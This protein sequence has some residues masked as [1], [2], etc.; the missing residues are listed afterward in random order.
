MQSQLDPDKMRLDD[1][2][3]M[4]GDIYGMK[5]RR[6]IDDSVLWAHVIE[7]IGE[8]AEDLR[9]G[10]LKKRKNHKGEW[11]G[12]EVNVPD[13]FAWL[14]AFV[15]RQGWQ[16]MLARI[17]GNVNKIQSFEA[18][19]FHLIEEAAE[20]AK[21]IRLKNEENLRD[22]VADVFAWIVGICIRYG[23]LSGAGPLK[24][25]EMTWTQYPNCC[26]HCGGNPCKE[27]CKTSDRGSP[28][29]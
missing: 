20:V 29:P 19:A 27:D 28:R 18:I 26:V 22:E 11:V 17:Y 16:E 23:T 10:E 3:K 15:N 8:L 14:C 2:V 21:E 12:I 1:W 4:F 7:E 24:L 5:N 25:D 13:V 6:L 9:K